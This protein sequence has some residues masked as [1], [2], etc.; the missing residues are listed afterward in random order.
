MQD[1]ILQLLEH[2]Q[3]E[4]VLLGL[5]ITRGVPVSLEVATK[6]LY[7]AYFHPHVEVNARA[8]YFLDQSSWIDVDK[9]PEKTWTRLPKQNFYLVEPEADLM[10]DWLNN[11]PLDSSLIN[12]GFINQILGKINL[13]DQAGAVF[14]FCVKHQIPLQEVSELIEC[15][16]LSFYLDD[17]QYY[18]NSP[19]YYDHDKQFPKHKLKHLPKEIGE[20]VNLTSLILDYHELIELPEEIGQ[21]TKLQRLYIRDNSLTHL[22][23]SIQQLTNLTYLDMTH[24]PLEH[25]PE[26]LLVCKNLRVLEGKN[27]GMKALPKNFG[28]LRELHYLDLSYNQIENLPRS[29][30]KLRELSTLYLNNNRLQTLPK[31]FTKFTRLCSL[32]LSKNRL[33]RLPGRFAQLSNLEDLNLNSNQLTHWYFEAHAL[34][35]LRS[36]DLRGN[37]LTRLLSSNIGALVSLELLRIDDNLIPRREMAQFKAQNPN[38]DLLPLIP[39]QEWGRFPKVVKPRDYKDIFEDDLELKVNFTEHTLYY[40]LGT[41][42]LPIKPW[43]EYEVLDKGKELILH[44]T[45]YNFFPS[46]EVLILPS[47]A[48]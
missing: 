39:K 14:L 26:E 27:C 45:E 17:H 22:P 47:R 15:T 37:R 18:L 11:L 23:E 28:Q 48:K 5:E 7:L 44:F 6:I 19:L 8:K 16:H 20:M 31:F 21:L 13:I 42:P 4:N 1:K 46:G 43:Q 9:I 32:D 41:P 3:E 2:E 34:F 40:S 24:N 25:F 38:L 30:G 10:L 35:S 12:A 29:F 36:L 33:K